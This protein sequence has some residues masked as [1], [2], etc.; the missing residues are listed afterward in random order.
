V[1]IVVFVDEAFE[2]GGAAAYGFVVKRDG[3]VIAKESGPLPSSNAA[4]YRALVV[5]LGWLLKHGIFDPSVVVCSDDRITVGELNG[6]RKVRSGQFE[7]L[8]GLV[9][10]LAAE[11]E[12]LA[13]RGGVDC[14]VCFERVPRALNEE[15]DSLAG[16]ALGCLRG[17]RNKGKN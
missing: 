11:L 16:R 8:H 13:N 1:R 12:R 7:Q 3:Q 2:R 6:A 9:L 15:A 4:T 10:G 17:R 14:K 5:A